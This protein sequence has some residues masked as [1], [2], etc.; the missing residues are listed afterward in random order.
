MLGTVC[1]TLPSFWSLFL[2]M[3]AAGI[4][5]VLLLLSIVVIL[6]YFGA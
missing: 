6:Y 5:I 3:L 2:T 1:N 4:P